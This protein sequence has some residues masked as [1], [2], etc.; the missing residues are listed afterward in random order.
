MAHVGHHTTQSR[1]DTGVTRHDA[2]GH[3]HFAHHGAHMQATATTK[4]HVGKLAWVVSFFDGH[5]T[6]RTRHLGIGHCQNSFSRFH[7]AQAQ[8]LSHMRLNGLL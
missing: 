8:G 2:R 5:H 6:H 3:T 7:G 1:C 4:W